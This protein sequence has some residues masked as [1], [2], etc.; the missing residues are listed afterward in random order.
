MQVSNKYFVIVLFCASIT[1]VLAD[2]IGSFDDFKEEVYAA[3]RKAAANKDKLT[4][5]SY[6][7]MS[8]HLTVIEKKSV[9]KE[10]YERVNITNKG[11]NLSLSINRPNEPVT[12]TEKK[13]NLVQ[14]NKQSTKKTK[15]TLPNLKNGVYVPPAPIAGQSNMA[16]YAPVLRQKRYGIKRNTWLEVKLDRTVSS[17]DTGTVE[18]ILLSPFTG[19][20]DV[21]PAQ[22]V[23]EAEARFN[24]GNKRLD[25]T[26]KKC[27][28]PD[29]KELDCS[30]TAY[31]L[32]GRNGL[33]GTLVRNKNS[34]IKDA[35]GAGMVDIGRSAVSAVTDGGIIGSGVNT[36]T[37]TLLENENQHRPKKAK[38]IIITNPQTLKIKIN[39][40]F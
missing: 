17:A 30:G 29:G 3:E 26:I 8:K 40:A 16:T 33:P 7:E 21:L 22:T 23:F 18:L 13:A 5:S 11:N 24:D 27:L 20:I 4:E 12:K 15:P 36:T 1:D 2:E 37:Q 34:E 38:T 32:S 14:P 31:D 39:Q 25:L 28:L 19:G 9:K 10:K 35:V 6:N